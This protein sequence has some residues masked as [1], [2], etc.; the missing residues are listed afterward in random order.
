MSTAPY[1]TGS[2]LMRL[3]GLAL[4]WLLLV[5]ILFPF[6][7]MISTSLKSKTDL[8]AYPPVWFPT[9]AVF[10]NYIDLWSAIPLAGYIRNSAIIAGGSMLLNAVVAIPAGFAL[11]R[12][13]FP[14]RQ[15]FLHLIVATQMFSPVVLLLATF[16]MMFDFGLL[17][18]YWS[19]IFVN[20]TTALPFT[21][22]MLTAYFATVPREIEEAAILDNAGRWRL[23]FDHFLPV[24][25]PGIVT[26]MTFAF[27]I[28]WNEFLFAVTF[29][30]DAGMR[31]LTTGI[32]TFVGR[33]ETL[34]NFL[35]AASLISIVPVFIGFLLVQRRLVS[36]LA[37][38][39][40]K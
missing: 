35:M 15:T 23:L 5:V 1:E 37:A 8:A 21:I 18:T 28:A 24:S 34:W 7:E 6:V 29:I 3:S 32:Y 17:N 27:V 12:F 40:V 10:R 19:V 31:P 4:L 25:M 36:G 14:G 2:R 11:A 13:R 26:A 39:A 9:N 16:R 30:T 22:W 33:F 38:G 20:A